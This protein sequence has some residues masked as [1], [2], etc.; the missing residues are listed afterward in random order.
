[1]R[2]PPFPERSDRVM[3]GPAHTAKT[4]PALPLVSVIVTSYNYDRFI[5]QTIKSVIEQSYP[6][7]ELIIV[8]DGS[9]DRSLDVIR[10]FQ[11]RRIQVLADGNHEGACAAYNKALVRCSGKYLLCLDS[12]DFIP[13]RKLERQTSFLELHPEIDILGSNVTEVNVNGN[14]SGTKYHHE[15]W[16]NQ[17]L[18]LNLPDNWCAQNHL[19]HSSVLL[20]KELHD[21]VGTFNN[22]LIYTP[23][24]EFWLRC[25]ARG[26]NICVL[27]EQLVFYRYHEGNVTGK[28]P[29][30]FIAE[31][32]YCI[33]RHL[34]PL[35]AGRKG[36]PESESLAVKCILGH[37]GYQK[38]GQ[39]EQANLLHVLV[40]PM[41]FEG[42]FEEFKRQLATA[43]D[44]PVQLLQKVLQDSAMSLAKNDSYI[45]E[46]ER[47]KE[48]LGGENKKKD[49]HIAELLKSKMWLESELE[50]RLR[51]IRDLEE[52]KRFLEGELAD[53][54]AALNGLNE[55]RIYL[56]KNLP[57]FRD[58]EE[59]RIH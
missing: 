30:R 9:S 42:S 40:N 7:W 2:H 18:D 53:V 24:Y 16:F 19:C 33:C 8:D 38:L 59:R 6:M 47:S 58:Q 48:W 29:K 4:D 36:R 15:A 52:A 32:G 3:P 11:D 13:P 28:D 57:R 51:F 37:A 34:K 55:T 50:R 20:R 27:R 46:L 35:L 17:I 22:D 49:D 12:D 45:S 31:L 5:G 56:D 10:S 23:D 39:D 14:P 41:P 1:M 43:P 44:S 26:A 54:R 25:L 21:K